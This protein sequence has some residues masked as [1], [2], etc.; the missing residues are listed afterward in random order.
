MSKERKEPLTKNLKEL[1]E[2]RGQ[3]IRELTEQ[4]IKGLI[5]MEI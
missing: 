4:M 5:E 2:P 1:R 3:M